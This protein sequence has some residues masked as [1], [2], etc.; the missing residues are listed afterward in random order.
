MVRLKHRYILFDVLYPPSKDPQTKSQHLLFES[1][2][3]A[4]TQLQASSPALVSD[5]AISRVL[6]RV[7]EDHYG[8]VGGAV[9]LLILVKYFS[10]RTLS[11]I[12]RCSRTD[13]KKVVAAL[14]LVTRVD[15]YNV[16]MRSVHV[17]GTIKKC[18]QAAIRRNRATIAE[19]QLC[20]EGV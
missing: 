7:V 18:E 6:K 11:G 10:N 1:F 9:A 3:G 4:P 19:L 16:V 14:A 8:E 17:S 13:F 5:K 12:V 15:S 20:G 2:S